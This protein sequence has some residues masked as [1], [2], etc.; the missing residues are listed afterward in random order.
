MS[1]KRVTIPKKTPFLSFFT[2]AGFLDVGFLQNG[3]R[4]L[5]HNEYYRPFVEAF[6]SGVA[7]LGYNGTSATVQNT[8]S[9]VEVGPN[10]IVAEAFLNSRPPAVFGVIGGPP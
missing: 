5:W 9:I 2:G 1:K 3:F 7:S 8:E 10:S 6:E 4:G